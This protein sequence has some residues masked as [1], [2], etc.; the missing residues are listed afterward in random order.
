MTPLSSDGRQSIYLLTKDQKGEGAQS[1]SRREDNLVR[2]SV[3]STDF[4]R[5]SMEPFRLHTTQAQTSSHVGHCCTYTTS[6]GV[7]R[8]SIA[9]AA[10]IAGPHK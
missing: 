2:S 4:E 9:V 5:P 8:M 1:E 6:G 7:W 3:T 10:S